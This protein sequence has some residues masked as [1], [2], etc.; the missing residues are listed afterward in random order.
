MDNLQGKS[1]PVSHLALLESHPPGGGS[2]Y[3]ERQMTFDHSVLHTESSKSSMK[4]R[5]LVIRYVRGRGKGEKGEGEGKGKE[6]RPEGEE[7]ELLSKSSFLI[8]ES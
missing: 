5:V 8:Q 6:G 3:F 2:Y 4:P 7:I 1:S